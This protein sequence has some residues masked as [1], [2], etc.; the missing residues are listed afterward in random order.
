MTNPGQP[1]ID[2]NDGTTHLSLRIPIRLLMR[3][4]A[5]CVGDGRNLSVVV[6]KLIADWLEGEEGE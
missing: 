4:R 1:R 6:R 3:L 5:K 2:P